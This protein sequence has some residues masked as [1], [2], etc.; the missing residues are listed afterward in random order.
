MAFTH[1]LPVQFKSLGM[2]RLK[3]IGGLVMSARFVKKT[4]G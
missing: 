3:Q 2:R 4:G 1:H